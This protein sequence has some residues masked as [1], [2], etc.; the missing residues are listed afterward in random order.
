MTMTTIRKAILMSAIFLIAVGTL[1]AQAPSAE[2]VIHSFVP[3]TGYYPSAVVRDAAGNF[4][5]ATGYGVSNPD[6]SHGCGAILK[7]SPS[8][9][10]KVL[11]AF[12]YS[13]F[14]GEG[15]FPNAPVRDAAGNLYMSTAFGGQAHR[16][17]SVFKLTPSDK[18]GFLYSFQGGQDGA[19][20]DSGLT[21]DS[22]GNLYG[23]TYA[24][25]SGC[26]N[27][28]PPG[29]GT[30]YR[31]TPLGVE[32]VLYRFTGGADGAFPS[33]APILDSAGNLYGTALLGGDLT[34]ALGQGLDCGTVWKLDTSGNLTVLYSFTGPDGGGPGAAL[35]M[36]STSDLYGVTGAG[37]DLSCNEG[38]GCGVV[39]EIDSSGNFSVLHS[40]VG[41][42]ADG[43][44]PQAALIEDAGGNLYGTTAA[45]GNQSCVNG[46]GVVFKL[47]PSGNET[48]L[49]YF[50][51]GTTDGWGP[52][53][54]LTTDGKGNLYGTT[55]LGG[56]ANG[57]VLFG[58]KAQ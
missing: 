9:Q 16:Y 34:C 3:A 24:G 35:L 58:V 49:H 30:V 6:C 22:E 57:G 45:G 7:L 5:V 31:V 15:P 19:T 2:K 27:Q 43:M 56:V 28:N 10:P 26:T 52:E 46:C 48:I 17:G 14:A 40:F 29:C 36:D 20:P 42:S 21:I 33:A 18:G 50:T 41:G 38:Y 4:Y 54:P 47:D 13:G 11:Y 44:G 1:R 32:T 55:V 39:F 23:S 53:S 25:G 12:G 37:G 8:G 51:G